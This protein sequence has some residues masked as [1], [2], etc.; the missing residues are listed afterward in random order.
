MI[1]LTVMVP[2]AWLPKPKEAGDRTTGATPLPD[3]DAVCGLFEAVSVTTSDV[4]RL[5]RAAGLN[6]MLMLQP[7]PAAKVFGVIGQ[8]PPKVKSP[9]AFPPDVAMLLIVSGEDCVF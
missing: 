2:S 1:V 7:R 9:G 5:P 3:R 4:V 8:F 6:V